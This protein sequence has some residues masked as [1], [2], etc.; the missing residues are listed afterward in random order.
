[1]HVSRLNVKIAMAQ[2]VPVNA[3]LHLQ[4]QSQKEIHKK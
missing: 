3:D 4:G 1:M 2:S